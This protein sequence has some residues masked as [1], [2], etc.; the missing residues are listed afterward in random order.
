M[1][2]TPG[3]RRD[4][5][6]FASANFADPSQWGE[7]IYPHPR[8]GDV[9]GKVFLGQML[10]LSGMEV[11]LGQLPPGVS[12]PFLHAHKQ[13]EELYLVI[14][15]EGEMQVD[16]EKI[17]LSPGS[18]IRVSPEGVRCWRNSGQEALNYLV[19]QAKAGSLE[20]ATAGDGV[21]PDRPLVWE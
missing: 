7:F 21:I 19:I 12:I 18:A 13:N 3:Q 5:A 11:S 2:R 20:Q 1:G 9:P 17:P 10:G 6:N 15:G 16:G 14:S 8:R 4:G